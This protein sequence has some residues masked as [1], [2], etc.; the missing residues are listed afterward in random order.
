MLIPLWADAQSPA[1]NYTGNVHGIDL[2]NI[3]RSADPCVDFYQYAN[4]GW[5][6]ANSI[7]PDESWWTSWHEV[8]DRNDVLL[9]RILEDEAARRERLASET[10]IGRLVGDLYASAMD[11]VRI[12]ALGLDPLQPDLDRVE[13]IGS[14]EGL[15]ELLG[16]LHAAGRDVLFSIFVVPDFHDSEMNLL[17]V[18][19]GG[20]GL[21]EKDY[22]FRS[23]SASVRLRDQ[24]LEHVATML[25]LAGS[26]REEAE[27]RA[28][29]ILKMETRLA[30]A[31]LG[32]VELRDL[33]NY[34]NPVEPDEAAAIAPAFDWSEHLRQMGVRDTRFSFPHTRFFSTLS[35]M[36][37]EVPLADWKGYL[38]WHLL[39]DAAPYLASPFE[40][41]H[42]R[43]YSTVL[44]GTEQMPPRWRRARGV[45]SALAGEALGQL[46]VAEAFPPEARAQALEMVEN[47]QE[48]LRDRLGRLAWMGDDTRE[49]ALA[50]LATFRPKIGYP[51]EW[52]DYSGY[53]V[54][55]TDFFG[56][57]LR[58]QAF[59]AR[60][61]YAKAG[62]PV[63][64]N[65][66]EM[67]PQAVNAYYNPT[68]NE[69]VFPAGIMQPPFFDA[70]ID[71]AVNYGAMGAVIGHEIMHGY[72]D[73]GSK[74]D[75]L[76]NMISWWTEADRTE[77]ERRA[78]SLVDQYG[79]FTA[80]DSLRVS[81]ELTLGENIG[82]LGG[83][84]ISYYGL[85]RALERGVR[86]TIDGFTPE[87]R[88]FL[89]W[90]QVWRSLQR[91]E[92]LRVLV[93]TD[94][95]APSLFRVIGPLQNMPEFADAFG[96][97]PGDPMVRV[98]PADIW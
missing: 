74:F 17:Y 8:R 56:N 98:E 94:P 23:D 50:K 72:D 46:F 10:E 18:T 24:Y 95:H 89:S 40:Q 59:E 36:L 48:A 66:W 79:G 4:G 19:Q 73:Q 75:A 45:V 58:G 49:Q 33:A 96:C 61:T 54:D 5:L 92:F 81:G 97:Q 51:D 91:D 80:V 71:P 7:P 84:I 67:V 53:H 87:Q 34:Y 85:Q 11:T 68:Q 43:F 62:Q 14:N 70:N 60:R 25:D 88:F 64:R 42:F 77:F 35:E 44:R 13:A 37:V 30:E 12:D 6:S 16:E 28:Q 2:Q 82:D 1:E 55:R 38:R 15:V 26:G 22:Y 52:R 63:D 31:S 39:R 93:Q 47:I 76:G 29:R 27:A 32:V 20:L 3:D 86:D 57:V 78:G 90:A 41:E 83:L 9:R 65:E 21:P 69:I